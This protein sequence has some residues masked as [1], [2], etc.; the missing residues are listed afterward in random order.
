MDLQKIIPYRKLSLKELLV[1]ENKFMALVAI[2]LTALFLIGVMIYLVHGHHAYGVTREHP[3]G[4]L[5]AMYIFFVVSSTG[6]CIV[7]SF[8]DVFGFKDYM[9]VS[10][11]A[12]FGSIITILS[13]FAVIAFEIGHPVR[14]MIYNV[15]SPG[16]TS[17]IWW[18]GTL[19]G[20][21]LTFMVIEF[22]F[23]MR[24]DMKR[25]KIF[26]LI[27]LLVGLAAHS[28]LGG[29][30]GFLNARVVANGVFY[31][32]YFI[33]TAFITGIYL[34]FLMYGYKYRGQPFP[35]DVAKALTNF[36]K[37]QGLLLAILMFFETWKMLTGVYGGMPERAD[38]IMHILHTKSF[39]LGEVLCGMVI[40][41]LVILKSKGTAI[42]SM[43]WASFI[44]MIG[45]FYM[46]YDLVHDAQLFPMQTLKIRE[47]QLPPSFVDY[48]PS[49]T[50]MMIG[51]G[52]IG[53]CLIL[54]FLG[55]KLFDLD[56]MPE[57][58]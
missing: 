2:V 27:G 7:G 13:G 35:E 14:M 42:K 9:A 23:L 8:G 18:M 25:A 16:L 50:E 58:H 26:G 40:P 53:L 17:A 46:R 29:V 54:Y 37:I 36:A 39:W 28:N 10:K 22:V 55:T 5:I 52:G 11:R 1:P 19:Y 47:Y 32:T 6:L 44:G 49:L 45:I 43:V 30:F 48:F 38:T 24:N 21:Y 15:I 41:F 57:H 3:W 51:F 31:P 20:I 56:S 4:L 12:I 34:I 33:L